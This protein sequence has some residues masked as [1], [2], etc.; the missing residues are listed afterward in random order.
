MD[1]NVRS[2]LLKDQRSKRKAMD[3]LKN[4][5][6]DRLFEAILS[7]KNAEEC[8]R[9]FEDLCTPKEIAEMSNRLFAAERLD[10][11][12]SYAEIFENTGLSSATISRVKRA[13]SGGSGGYRL[14]IDRMEIKKDNG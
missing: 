1:S 5:K 12:S 14:V 8:Q 13:L 7:L 6:A 3:N 4:E 11:K 2:M 10:E 9:F